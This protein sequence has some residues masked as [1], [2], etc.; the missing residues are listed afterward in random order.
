MPDMQQFSTNREVN[1]RRPSQINPNRILHKPKTR[2]KKIIQNKKQIRVRPTDPK[3]NLRQITYNKPPN[4]LISIRFNQ[5]FQV[6]LK[7]K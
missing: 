3:P 6:S 1:N 5:K 2:P 4:L 7:T